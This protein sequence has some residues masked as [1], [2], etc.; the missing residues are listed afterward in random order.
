MRE[1]LFR[2]KRIDNG[3]WVEGWYIQTNT[4]EHRIANIA[5]NGLPE[6][7]PIDYVSIGQF[8]GL[9]D[10]NG[11]RIFEGDVLR[12]WRGIGASG[13]LRGEYTNPLP[14]KYC[15]LWCQFVVEDQSIKMQYGIWQQFST[16][17]VISTIHDEVTP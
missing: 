10:K 13:E 15:P 9:Y 6:L 1:I 12:L 5:E 17:E 7:Y 4:G 8:T 14:V 11:K 3:E 2:G 16:Y